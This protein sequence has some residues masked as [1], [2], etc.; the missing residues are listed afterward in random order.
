[1]SYEEVLNHHDPKQ[2]YAMFRF[3]ASCCQLQMQLILPHSPSLLPPGQGPSAAAEFP[4]LPG[5][6]KAYWANSDNF[7]I[8]N[9]FNIKKRYYMD[10]N[11]NNIF[12]T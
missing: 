4:S 2:K 5:P 1:M 7:S 9:F 6:H 11:N 12:K 8:H 10:D 3:M